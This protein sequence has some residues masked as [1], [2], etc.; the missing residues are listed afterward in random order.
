MLREFIYI[1]V[2]G[3]LGA[4]GRYYMAGLTH[5]VLGD[6]FPYGTLIV[7]VAGSFLLGFVVQVG[8]STD[9]LPRSLRLA[10]TFGFLGAFTT[11]SAFSYET[12]GYIEDGSWM[13]VG[14][15]VLANVLP[16]I[17]A[18]FLG[19]LLGRTMLGGA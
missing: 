3:G 12:F 8:M 18:V 5:R 19:V 17:I 4:I 13:M 2:A 16:A 10:I 9:I 15:N 11:F 6:G 14:V 1:A 7:N